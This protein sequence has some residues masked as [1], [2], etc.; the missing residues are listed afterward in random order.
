MT[1]MQTSHD[2]T[3]ALPV[4]NALVSEADL[5]ILYGSQ[6][7][8]AEFLAHQIFEK[9]ETVGI[10]AEIQTLN[11]ALENN[12]LTWKRL[13]IVTST[14]DNGHMPENSDA[15]WE[16]LK[17]APDNVYEGLPYSV[18]TIGDS[19]YDDFCKAGQ[20]LDQ[21]FAELGARSIAP[22][23][24]CD[25]DFDMTSTKWI[26]EFLALAPDAD[27]WHPTRLVTPVL[28]GAGAYGTEAEPVCS[29]VV[30]ATRQ[31]SGAGSSKRVI[32]Y[33]LCVD[34]DFVY[35]CG[36]SLDVFPANPQTLVSQWLEHFPAAE[37]VSVDGIMYSLTDVLSNH[38]ELRLPHLGLVKAL[39]SHCAESSAAQE[40]MALLE[41]GNRQG[42]DTWLWGR[43]VLDVVKEFGVGAPDLQLVI[44]A[45]RPIQRRSYSIAS[46]P[47]KEGNLVRLTVSSVSYER[48]GRSHVGVGTHFLERAAAT[49]EKLRI[50]RVAAHEF[51]LPMDDAPIIMIGPGVGVA[52]FIGFLH[53]I[54][55]AKA[56]NTTWLFFGDRHR[57]D[58]WLYEEQMRRWQENGTLNELD[59]AFSR[60]QAGK[61]YVQDD[62]LR[63]GEELLSWI[64]SGAHI[65]VCG[66]KN[67]MARD[68]ESALIDILSPDGQHELGYAR[69]E[70]LRARG[71][72]AKDVY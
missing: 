41:S 48:A 18:L 19:M 67:R 59:L 7:G 16:W 52:P 14:H 1:I 40:A 21:R 17:Q 51:R 53:D 65:Y 35:K 23:R 57:T 71:R 8:N 37:P 47:R 22:R 2:S 30:T 69:L 3:G 5:T 6:T 34:G 25:V 60:D 12:Q 64:N 36:D 62:L 58:D 28:G 49:G 26:K 46:S 13:L 70:E 44:D 42:M 63:R 10:L 56:H 43:D 45:L 33:E 66:D 15:F 38:L 9:A 24:E 72:Y 50:Q 11:D 39:A 31:L 27:P 54:E 32:H 20:D 68:V 61:H 55:D 4:N 29:A